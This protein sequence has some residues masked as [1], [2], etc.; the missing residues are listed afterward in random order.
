ME[1]ITTA[2]PTP[3]YPD[4]RV[5]YRKLEANMARL[6]RSLVTG[7]LLL[8]STGEANHLSDAESAEVLRVAA[9]AAAAEKVLLAGVGR[10][11]V[12]STLELAEGAAKASYDA[13]LV[14]PPAYYGAQRTPAAVAHYYRSVADRSPLPVVLYHIPHNVPVDLPVEL[15]AELAGHANIIGIKD[16]SGSV[17]RIRALVE[18]TRT[19]R[20]RSF[21]VTNVFAPVTA[22]MLATRPASESAL[23]TIGATTTPEPVLPELKTRRK[24]VGFQVLCGTASIFLDALEAGAVGGILAFASF[25]PEACHEIFQALRDHDPQLARAK[26]ERIAAVNQRIVTELGIG[27]VKYACDFN[28]FFGGYPRQPLLPPTAAVKAEIEQLLAGIRN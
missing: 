3:F 15:V 19:A 8:G 27:A 5:Y 6:S 1:G 22:R 28:G 18:A 24:E 17:E 10:D 12:R 14:R 7:M 13:V 4:E 16:S 9:G 20:P 26:Q 11:S 25:A 2:V 23:V 21:A